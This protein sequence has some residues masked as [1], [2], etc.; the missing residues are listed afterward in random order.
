MIEFFW[1]PD[2]KHP[3]P[4]FRHP[5]L[6]TLSPIL[7]LEKVLPGTGLVE[8]AEDAAGNVYFRCAL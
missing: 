6:V 1:R 3:C 2:R 4:D 7:E 8:V 5:Y